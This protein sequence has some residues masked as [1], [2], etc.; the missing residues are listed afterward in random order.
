MTSVPTSDRDPVKLN[1]PRLPT[2][3][4]FSLGSPILINLSGDFVIPHEGIPYLGDLNPD[5]RLEH[6]DAFLSQLD[7]ALDSTRENSSEA[8]SQERLRNLLGNAL[9]E[10]A[11]QYR[12]LTNLGPPKILVLSISCKVSPQ[13]HQTDYTFALKWENDVHKLE[14]PSVIA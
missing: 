11:S 9:G 12:T 14:H 13:T 2:G 6:L 7:L 4:S 3:M 5:L 1:D 8:S 10:V